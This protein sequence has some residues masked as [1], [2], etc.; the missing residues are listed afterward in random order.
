MIAKIINV[1]Y[2]GGFFLMSRVSLFIAIFFAS[3]SALHAQ[4]SVVAKVNGAVIT[5]RDVEVEIDRLLPSA[6]FHGNVKPETRIHLRDKAVE[7]LIVQQMQYQDAVQ[8]GLKPDKKEVKGRMNQIRDRFKSKKDYKAALEQAKITEDELRSRIEREVLIQTVISK[9]ID[10]PA[11]VDDATVKQ[12]YD[13]N[14]EKF[15][16]PEAIRLF[17]I[18]T[19]D[20][21]KAKNAFSKIKAGQNFSDI[22]ASVSEDDYRVLGGN[23]GIIHRGRLN[24]KIEKEAFRLKPGEMS[25]PILADR[26]WYILKVEEKKPEHQ[27]TFEE[28]K[29]KLKN[30]LEAERAADLMEK[31]LS[32]LRSKTKIERLAVQATKK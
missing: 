7:N 22:A 17:E 3:V 31:W 20:K 29:R 32:G 13:K 10:E 26:T 2:K 16:Q 21:K 9:T 11:R 1:P 8:R 14:I 25:A 28:I 30:A 4:D 18:S 12:Y 6:T 27:M 23:M 24:P 5:S 19:H 15:K